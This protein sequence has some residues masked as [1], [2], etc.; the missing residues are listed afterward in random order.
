MR[1]P[2]DL[3]RL[4]GVAAAWSFL[5]VPVVLVGAVAGLGMVTQPGAGPDRMDAG[6]LELANRSGTDAEHAES[7]AELVRIADLVVV[8]TIRDVERGRTVG[9][10][11]APCRHGCS[12][13]YYANALL[14][15]E[16]VVSG[17]PAYDG[18]IVLDL[19]MT[20][21]DQ[22][23]SIRE[24]LQGQRGLFILRNKGENAKRWGL[25]R[26]IQRERTKYYR[27][28]SSQALYRDD[29]GKVR[30]P[31]DAEDDFVLN[32]RGRE[33]SALVDQVSSLAAQ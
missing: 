7:M 25:S 12:L 33:F 2:V 21:P 31:V 30:P 29:G 28:V 18:D 9:D 26:E 1:T 3:T 22:L 16:K 14:N 23:K 11:S 20:E 24:S 6:W 5:V 4:R 8:A 13:G 17:S 27:L 15:V 10:P 32:Q 19:F